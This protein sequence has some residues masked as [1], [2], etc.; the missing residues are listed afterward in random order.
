MKINELNNQFEESHFE[1]IEPLESRICHDPNHFPP[2]MMVIPP[3]KKY[4]HVCQTCGAK[5]VIFGKSVW[6]GVR[7]KGYT[8][9]YNNQ[10]S[11]LNID[12]NSFSIKN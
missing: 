12:S 1:D 3:N 10:S 6:C 9:N 7:D 11:T 5:S 2:S 4:I 8:L